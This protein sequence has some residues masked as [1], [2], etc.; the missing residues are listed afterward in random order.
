M[1]KSERDVMQSARAQASAA[2]WR[3]WRNNVG[4]VLTTDGRFVRFGL[5]NE[6]A[7][8]N[9]SLKSSDLIGIRPVQIGGVTIGQ[10]VAVECK[11]PGG[12]VL[13]AQQKY[14]DLVR[15]L[16]GHAVLYDGEGDL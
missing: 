1:P 12:R 14:L 7:A 6:S 11:R 15:S 4:A 8:M 2:G 13:H 10:F 3:L 16:G 5:C 9:R